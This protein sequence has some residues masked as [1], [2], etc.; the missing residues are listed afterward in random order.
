MLDVME[1]I[2]WVLAGILLLALG[3]VFYFLGVPS[4]EPLIAM[5]AQTV[6]TQAEFEKGLKDDAKKDLEEQLEEGVRSLSASGS[7]RA[8]A[9]GRVNRD[10][11]KINR[12][13]FERVSTRND[14]LYEANKI[15]SEIVEVNGQS[16]MKLTE[17]PASSPLAELGFKELDVITSIGNIDVDFASATSADDAF[18]DAKA[19]LE[20]G[21]ALVITLQRGARGTPHQVA[22]SL[23]DLNGS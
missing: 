11:K 10:F 20:S 23:S 22:I 21:S 2:A 5:H 14:A 8:G 6:K 19:I 13:L 3:A 17:I 7:S 4:T 15:S 9:S 12:P 18:A 16:A 1:K